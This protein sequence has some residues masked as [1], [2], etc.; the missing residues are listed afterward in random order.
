MQVKLFEIRDR[1]TLIPVMATFFDGAESPLLRV[2]G[3]AAGEHYVILTKLTGGEC[4][5]EYDPFNWPANPRTM[6]EAHRFIATSP[7]GDLQDGQVI[8]VEFLQ[9]ETSAPKTSDCH[10]MI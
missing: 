2:A 1:G 7:W 8:D 4:S 6:R 9:G 10:A 3:Y 5:A